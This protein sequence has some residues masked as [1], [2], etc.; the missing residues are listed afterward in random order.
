MRTIK[1]KMIVTLKQFTKDRCEDMDID[2]DDFEPGPELDA[3]ASE[4]IAD[5]VVEYFED[6][7]RVDDLLA[8]SGLMVDFSSVK[9]I[10]VD[11]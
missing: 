4:D 10:P 6:T 1:L 9:C 11:V 3:V 7:Q 5:A 2:W 8:G